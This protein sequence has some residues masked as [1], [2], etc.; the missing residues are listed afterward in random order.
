MGQHRCEGLLCGGQAE[1]GIRPRWHPCDSS[2][3]CQSIP[4]LLTVCRLFTTVER[5]TVCADRRLKASLFTS[6]GKPQCDFIARNRFSQME[7]PRIPLN[8]PALR[9][10]CSVFRIFGHT[11]S[12][13][14]DCTGRSCLPTATVRGVGIGWASACGLA[15]FQF[16]SVF[17][18]VL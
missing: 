18:K 4:A 6:C 13:R 8:L 12:I 10:L 15:L 7:F 16:G 2:I 3:C 1:P 9:S 14:I 5:I 17:C 11:S